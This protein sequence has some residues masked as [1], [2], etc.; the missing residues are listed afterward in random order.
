[1]NK[2]AFLYIIAAGVLWGT[3]GIFFNLLT[4]YGFSPM[5]MTAM[6]A[7]V[8]ALVMI[9]YTLYTDRRLFCVSPKKIVAFAISGLCIFATAFC[10]YTSMKASSVSVAVILMYT[11]PVFVMI[12]S[13][14]FFGEK[15]NFAKLLS[16]CFMIVGCA[17]VSGIAGGMKLSVAGVVFGLGAGLSYSGY[18]IAAKVVAMQRS[19]HLTATTYCFVV[20]SI[21]S[22]AFANPAEMVSLASVDPAIVIP[23]II[24]IGVCTCVLPYFLYSQSLKNIPVGTASAL[25]IVEPLAATLFSVLI[26]GEKLKVFSVCGIILILFAV[27]ILGREKE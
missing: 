17:L 5:Q 10:Y 20:M 21:M 12:I 4:P 26:F 27:Y 22:L 9:I 13:V 15:F 23:L 1:M 8:S 16:L 25:S 11:A 6:R 7:T 24:G 3:S 18:N 19:H 14:A 2:K